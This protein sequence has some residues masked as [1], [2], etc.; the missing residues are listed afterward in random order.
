[1]QFSNLSCSICSI[2][3]TYYIVQDDDSSALSLNVFIILW[4]FGCK[5]VIVQLSYW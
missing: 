3:T 1:M 5:I 4:H 2:T